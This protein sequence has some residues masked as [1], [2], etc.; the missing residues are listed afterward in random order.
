MHGRPS[1]PIECG[2]EVTKHVLGVALE[3]DSDAMWSWAAWRHRTQHG[4]PLT[5]GRVVQWLGDQW[6]RR[7]TRSSTVDDVTSEEHFVDWWASVQAEMVATAARL[8]P[9]RRDTPSFAQ[10]AQAESERH[11]QAVQAEHAARRAARAAVVAEAAK[12]RRQRRVPHRDRSAYEAY[13]RLRAHAE[14]LDEGPDAPLT[15]STSP[16]EDEGSMH[17]RWCDAACDTMHA[18]ERHAGERKRPRCVS[19]QQQQ[20]QRRRRSQWDGWLTHAEMRMNASGM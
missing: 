15:I 6:D 11:T 12:A 14:T 20:V 13:Y 2:D 17:E 9:W 18:G 4:W 7:A 10:A 5:D 3:C 8:H 16:G 1:R 19:Q